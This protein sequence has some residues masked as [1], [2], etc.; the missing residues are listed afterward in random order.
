MTNHT[1]T[2]FPWQNEQWQYLQKRLQQRCLPHALLLSGVP[3]VGKAEFAQAFIQSLLCQQR[4]EHGFGC[5]QCDACTWFIAGTHPDFL[6]VQPEENSATIKIDAIRILIDRLSQAAHQGG[7]KIALITPAEA[8]PIAATNALLKI[9]EEPTP[10]TILILISHQ[11]KIIAATIRSRCQNILF[12]S[13][14]INVS[15]PWLSKELNITLQ[16][17]TVLLAKADGAPLIAKYLQQN[18][19]LQDQ[20]H[21]LLQLEQ[22]LAKKVTPLDVANKLADKALMDILNCWQIWLAQLLQ[23]QLGV[24]RNTQVDSLESNTLKKIANHLNGKSIYYFYD[25]V[26]ILRQQL[27]TKYNPNPLLAL[28]DLLCSWANLNSNSGQF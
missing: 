4:N 21:M 1:H 27:L 23:Y 7:Y 9:L 10:Q 25:K 17:A 19:Q 13:P 3:G 22:I 24:N 5:G 2:P 16:D 26:N 6:M 15:A 14:N 20:Q 11:P 18:V 12:T 28:E 8:M